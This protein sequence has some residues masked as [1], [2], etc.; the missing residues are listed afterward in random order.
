M[1]TD[2]QTAAQSGGG[3]SQNLGVV[4]SFEGKKMGAVN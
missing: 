4:N 3:E 1:G 2:W